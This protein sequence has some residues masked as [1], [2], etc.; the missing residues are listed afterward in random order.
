MW[1]NAPE[2]GHRHGELEDLVKAATKAGG[3]FEVMAALVRVG[4]QWSSYPAAQL[5]EMRTLRM[6]PIPHCHPNPAQPTSCSSALD[7]HDA[8]PMAPAL[9][10][11]TCPLPAPL[12]ATPLQ[13]SLLRQDLP[14]LDVHCIHPMAPL[15]A[16]PLH[17][18]LVRAPPAGSPLAGCVLRPLSTQTGSHSSGRSPRYSHVGRGH[19]RWWRRG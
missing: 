15:P 6:Q 10:P 9:L 16:P 4:R 8:P 11:P 5:H 18:S 2:E 3:C 12:S 19:G 13:F 1:G 7:A 17:T 14:S